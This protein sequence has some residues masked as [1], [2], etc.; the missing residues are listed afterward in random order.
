[1]P[2]QPK[3]PDI[4]E[5]DVAYI[6]AEGLASDDQGLLDLL[7]SFDSVDDPENAKDEYMSKFE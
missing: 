6:I 7:A 4:N 5:E 3:A 1:M 2:K